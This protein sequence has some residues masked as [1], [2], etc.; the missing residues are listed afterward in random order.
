MV[1]RA[2]FTSKQAE[3]VTPEFICRPI[4]DALAL[5]FD[6][7]ASHENAKLPFYATK[8][9]VFKR[10]FSIPARVQRMYADGLAASWEG[11]RVWLNPPYSRGPDGLEA[12]VRKAARERQRCAVSAV[13][14][15]ART[16]TDWFQRW[17]FPH[18]ECHFVMGRI[19]FIGG[20]S[21][22]PFPSV[23]AI[24]APTIR[25]RPGEIC[26]YTWDPRTSEFVSPGVPRR[27]PPSGH[28]LRV[29]TE[30]TR[31]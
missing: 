29:T 15:P 2:L 7:A 8:D 21:S 25:I 16:E 30:S 12:W 28:V 17:V 20:A 22:A 9:G 11:K 3:Y 6:G 24:Y 18:A 10:N 23:V 19:R 13:L 1:D 31:T 27:A 14:L 5:D 4:I 26:G